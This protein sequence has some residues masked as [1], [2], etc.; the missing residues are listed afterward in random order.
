MAIQSH[1]FAF[2]EVPINKSRDKIILKWLTLFYLKSFLKA[3]DA[4]SHVF[5]FCVMSD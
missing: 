4:L 3:Y 2:R 1:F 5:S